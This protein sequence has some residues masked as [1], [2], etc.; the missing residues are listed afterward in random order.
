[1]LEHFQWKTSEEIDTYL[2]DHA[3]DVGEEL[4][5]VLYWVLLMANNLNIDIA[6]AFE[7]KMTQ[8]RKKYP[9]E[10]AKGSHRKY[11]EL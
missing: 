6:T 9:V 5:D 4:I 2:R 10:K 3:D 8:N 1:M 7:K 11:S